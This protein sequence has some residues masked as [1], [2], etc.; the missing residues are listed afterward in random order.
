MFLSATRGDRYNIAAQVRAYIMQKYK[1]GRGP[2]RDFLSDA[3]FSN[4]D[5]ETG[6][7][8]VMLT[9]LA[10][11]MYYVLV[12]VCTHSLDTNTYEFERLNI[13]E[14]AREDSVPSEIKAS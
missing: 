8:Y 2:R 10:I 14:S 9:S 3:P 1:E 6:E 7:C 5:S 11:A 12:Y 4:L 13:S